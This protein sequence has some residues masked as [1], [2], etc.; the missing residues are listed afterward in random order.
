MTVVRNRAKEHANYKNTWITPWKHFNKINEAFGNSFILDV[1]ASSQDSRCPSCITADENALTRDWDPIPYIIPDWGN[2]HALWWSN[3]PF[4]LIDD[5]L[6]KAYQEMEL[7]NYGLMLVP[8]NQETKWF[9]QLIVSRDMPTLVY[10]SR[11]QFED[12]D[13]KPEDKKKGGNPVGTVLV[14]FMKK[15]K[16]DLPSVCGEPWRVNLTRL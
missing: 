14:A 6:E 15:S 12:P 11:I 2:R 16:I 8:S 10:P 7:G 9:R 1:S 3:P 4:D 13:R 5:F